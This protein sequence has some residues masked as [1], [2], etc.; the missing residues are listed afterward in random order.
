MDLK[1]RIKE[2]ANQY[3]DDTVGIRR[4][5]HKYPELSYQEFETSEYIKKQLQLLGIPFKDGFVKT[6]IVGRIVGKNPEKKIIAL[7]AD[8]DALPIQEENE[9]EYKSVN[10]GVMHACGHDV[11]SA[12]L[13]GTARILNEIRDY[14]EGT[15]LLIFQP[16][17][18][19]LPGGAKLMMEEGALDNP[20]PELIIG[21]HVYPTLEAGKV[22]FKKGMYMASTDEI[23]MTIKGTGGHA[24]MPHQISDT[25]LTT[26][27]II[28]AL[29]Q[30]VSR[31]G[32]AATPS[33]LSFGKV[34][35]NGA[36]NIIPSEVKVEGTFR[37]MDEEWRNKA[38]EKIR[39]IAQNVA[40]AMD[41]EVVIDIK[42]G[43]PYLVNDDQVT[44]L[45]QN[46]ARELL[47]G[48]NVIALDLRMTAEDFAYFSQHYPATFYRLGVKNEQLQSPLHSSTFN[49]DEKALKTAMETMAWI[50]VQSLNGG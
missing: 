9:V 19:K 2:L 1:A 10:N 14:F 46:A 3:F 49:I 12:S 28:A 16:A 4:H 21:Q 34:I 25:V 41:C 37:T 48:E 24:A 13:L 18:E 42:K 11:H 36:T 33:V 20:K 15:I 22:G 39:Q 6:G 30:I 32:E 31:R 40:N 23:Y 17:E 43:Y 44:D 45:A 5:I 38:H 29:Q 7:R 27:H 26:S 47:G 35:A 50:A 8:M